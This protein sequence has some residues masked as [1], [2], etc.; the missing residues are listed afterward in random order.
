MAARCWSGMNGMRRWKV[1]N[2]REKQI[3][4]GSRVTKLAWIEALNPNWHDLFEEI[5]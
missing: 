4:G 3:K 2:C 1:P 5:A